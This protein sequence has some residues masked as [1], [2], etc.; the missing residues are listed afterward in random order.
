MYVYNIDNCEHCSQVFVL[1][2]YYC[3]AVK[4]FAYVYEREKKKYERKN[5]LKIHLQCE[6]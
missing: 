4:Q 1:V 6:Y 2:H 3:V 5:K